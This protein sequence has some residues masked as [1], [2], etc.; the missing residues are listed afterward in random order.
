MTHCRQNQAHQGFWDEVR[1]CDD[2]LF[3]MK[4]PFGLD[5][6]GIIPM[7]EG[8]AVWDASDPDDP[9]IWW[10]TSY[11]TRRR[12]MV[13]QLAISEYVESEVSDSTSL[14]A[15]IFRYSLPIRALKVSS[16]A[17]PNI[18]SGDGTFRPIKDRD[19]II[20]NFGEDIVTRHDHEQL[21]DELRRGASGV[22][23]LKISD[24]LE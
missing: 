17:V 16:G 13:S 4:E 10:T 3:D 5:W 6:A 14:Y 12:R 18:I 22:Y 24:L 21:L 8:A 2:A 15:R 7:R 11:L 23:A 9:M 1:Q 19:I 20:N